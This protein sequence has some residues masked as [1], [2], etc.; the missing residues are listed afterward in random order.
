LEVALIASFQAKRKNA[1]TAHE[2]KLFPDK[3]FE[4]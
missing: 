2:T 3:E 4:N 1:I